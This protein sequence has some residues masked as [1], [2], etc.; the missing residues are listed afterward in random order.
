V[1]LQEVTLGGE[2][3]LMA[4]T[5]PP[6]DPE[7]WAAA[8]GPELLPLV[9]DWEVWK[10][11]QL[12]MGHDSARKDPGGA[13]AAARVLGGGREVVEGRVIEPGQQQQQQRWGQ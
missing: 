1:L 9:V 8:L 13:A 12:D 7:A 2:G 4:L 6:L 3:D 10:P 5:G 11:I